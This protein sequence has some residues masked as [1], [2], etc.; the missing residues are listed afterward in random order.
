MIKLDIDLAYLTK[1][2]EIGTQR[3]NQYSTKSI[4]E[5]MEAEA[6]QGNG[7][8][9]SFQDKVLKNPK[10][11]IKLL[12]LS[13]PKNRYAILSNLNS[14]DLEYVMQFLEPDALL[15]GLMF[16]T[17]DKILNLI[18][19]LPKNKIC[20]I[21]FQA[22][23]PEK[24][25]KM[26][27]EKEI[28][29]FFDSNKLDKNKIMEYVKTIPNDKLNK[30]MKKFLYQQTGKVQDDLNMDK[31][32]VVKFLDKLQP[33]K[34][35]EALKCFEKDV[36]NAMILELTRKDPNLFMEFSKNALT[37][38]LQQLDKDS[39]VKCMDKLSPDDLMKMVNELP[40][41]LLAIV[42]TQIDPM[43]FSEILSKDFQKILSEIG[44]GNL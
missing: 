17:K 5:M 27:P 40:D 21:L 25:L 2:F 14:R 30:M 22:V 26:L 36:K 39:I 28:N 7:K 18:Y 19:D 16:F 9:E 1:N 11:L 31:E 24:F 43:L 4:D 3:V 35:K 44:V 13:N 12:K 20:K 6:S 23:S 33:D 8:A 32:S 34:F 37:M 38:P 41:D 15:A 10:E 29:K 42:A